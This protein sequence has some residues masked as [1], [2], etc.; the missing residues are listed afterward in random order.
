M[1]GVEEAFAFCSLSVSFLSLVL[2]VP[3]LQSERRTRCEAPLSTCISVPAGAAA[4]SNDG[5]TRDF[6]QAGI[7]GLKAAVCQR[8]P[9]PGKLSVV[10]LKSRTRCLH[11][12]ANEQVPQE[13]DERFEKLDP[14]LQSAGCSAPF[15]ACSSWLL[16]WSCK[17]PD[18][19][20]RPTIIT[21]GRV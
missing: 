20:L 10:P 5:A 1:T 19:A 12:F 21:P 17:D 2:S 6:T 14:F 8:C 9:V 13:L 4:A 11:M 3:F 16:T 7:Q 15:L 18:S